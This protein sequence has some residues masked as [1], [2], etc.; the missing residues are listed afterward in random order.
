MFVDWEQSFHPQK[1]C[2]LQPNI[3]N[4]RIAC[5]SPAQRTNLRPQNLTWPLSSQLLLFLTLKGWSLRKRANSTNME[6][7]WLHTSSM[8]ML[9]PWKRLAACALTQLLS[10][11]LDFGMDSSVTQSIAELKRISTQTKQISNQ[12]LKDQ[13]HPHLHAHPQPCPEQPLA[14]PRFTYPDL[15]GMHGWN[16]T[17]SLGIFR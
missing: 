17:L 11:L 12:L 6:D 13:P 15:H 14:E 9:Q 3:T 16:F 10:H 7:I 4:V 8:A 1:G 2:K 5:L